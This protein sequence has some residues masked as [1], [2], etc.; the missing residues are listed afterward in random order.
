MLI[1][2]F[3]N[4][5]DDCDLIDLS[6]QSFESVKTIQTL[7]LRWLFDK[8]N[9]HDYWMYREGQK[10]GCAYDTNAFIHW[11]NQFHPDYAAKLIRQHVRIGNDHPTLFF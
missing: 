3:Y 8:N 4:S 1:Y 11:L 2:V 6:T 10:Y 9:E 5:S 7:F